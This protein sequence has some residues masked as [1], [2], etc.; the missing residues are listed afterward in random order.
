MCVCVWVPPSVLTRAE[1]DAFEK[2]RQAGWMDSSNVETLNESGYSRFPKGRFAGLLQKQKLQIA[3]KYKHRFPRKSLHLPFHQSPNS[4][5]CQAVNAEPIAACRISRVGV[6]ALSVH[7]ERTPG[8]PWH[9]C[10]VWYKR[11][12]TKVCPKTFCC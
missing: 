1:M 12:R 5:F 10:V 2:I 11:A 4:S 6:A 9:L 7:A 8:L 3:H